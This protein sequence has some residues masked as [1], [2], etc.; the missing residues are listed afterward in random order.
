VCDGENGR[1]EG[2]GTVCGPDACEDIIEG[3]CCLGSVCLVLEPAVCAGEEGEYLGDG[4]ECREDSCI[5]G[6]PAG[7]CCFGADCA[8]LGPDACEKAGGSYLGDN[9]TCSEACADMN[10]DGIRDDNCLYWICN[11]VGCDTTSTVYADMGGQ[12]GQ[13]FADLA[14]DGND[15]FQ[16]LNC[17]ANQDVLGNPS[18]FP[19]E[20]INVD[21]G[22]QFGGCAADGVCDA[23]DAF[24]ALN[25]FTGGSPCACPN[26]GP[27]PQ[28]EVLPQ[29]TERVT[30]TLRPSMP[31]VKPGQLVAVDV[32]FDGPLADLRGYQLHL[33]SAGGQRGRLELVDIAVLDE[34]GHVFSSQADWRV[35]NVE[36]GQM[37]AGLDGAGV[38]TRA[39]GYLA[40]F[41]YRASADA[42]GR[43]TVD[44]LHDGADPAQRTFVFATPANGKIDVV[45]TTPALI[46]VG[47]GRA[48]GAERD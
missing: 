18:A 28:V 26:G 39:G 1:Y 7:A 31:H 25:S 29:V 24:H 44:L 10:L 48:T 13:C 47:R 41:V 30:V 9:T 40:T 17:F 34:A 35:F 23:N 43:F 8:I 42:A 15:K 27:A 46:G 22:G 38:A 37:I 32:F 6:S 4:S 21:A 12:F 3:A 19:C 11:G 20:H 14:A 5:E 45:A 16:A 33:G 36:T 2:D